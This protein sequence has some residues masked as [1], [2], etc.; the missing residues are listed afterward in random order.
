M[1]HDYVNGFIQCGQQQNKIDADKLTP[2]KL[3]T[4]MAQACDGEI[5][6][7]EVVKQFLAWDDKLSFL[8]FCIA[9]NSN[10]SMDDHTFGANILWVAAALSVHHDETK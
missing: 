4:L 5:C 8:K 3:I 2:E 1:I 9:K 10:G 6:E 7:E